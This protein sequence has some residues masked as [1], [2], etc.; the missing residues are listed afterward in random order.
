MFRHERPSHRF[1]TVVRDQDGGAVL[2]VARGKGAAALKRFERKIAPF[3]ENMKTV[4]MDMASS[5]TSW[6][7]GRARL[8][9][10]SAVLGRVATTH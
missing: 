5:Y 9:S 1:I 7:A 6:A 10:A 3:K 2:A 4:S 8:Q